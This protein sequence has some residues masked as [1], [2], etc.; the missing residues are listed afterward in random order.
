MI[1]RTLPGTTV[2]VKAGERE[3]KLSA[4]GVVAMPL[5]L[6]WGDTVTVIERGERT[7]LP[8]GYELGDSKLKLPNEVLRSAQRL[9][10]YRLNA[11][12]PKAQATVAAGITAS[13]KHGGARGNDLKLT[14]TSIE[15]RWQI[16]TFLGT[17]EVDAQTIA[18]VADFVNNG[19]ITLAGSGDLAA[20]TVSLSGGSDGEIESGAYTAFMNELEKQQYNII[21][22]TGSDSTVA[23]SLVDFVERQ[24]LNDVNVQLVQSVISADNKAVY[25]NAVG[26]ITAG[27]T[28]SAAEASATLAGI[29]AK[30]G[31]TGSATYF[32]VA[33]WQDVNPR[34]TK[35]QQEVK[36]K[37]GEVLFVYMHGAVKL[38]YDINSLTTFTEEN[39]RD[40]CKGLVVRTLDQMASDIKILLDTKAIGKIRNSVDGRARIKGMLVTM[41]KAQYLDRGYLE[42]FNA[43]D[44]TVE[45][46]N[47]RDAIAVTVGVKVA[48]TV[49]KI[50]VTVTTL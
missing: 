28:L 16:K 39:P 21:A 10:L 15:G 30:Q 7:L 1:T 5:S 44:L 8:L 2:D 23:Q 3:A 29:L 40:F 41:L 33:W 48:D 38:L 26:G 20:V 11:G 46:G 45:E 32:D 4:V 25:K 36:T 37:A 43:D 34:L 49:D 50:Y 6:S 47:E 13:A 18:G 14:V 31:I 17:A 27:Y 9:I 19:F 42:A 24:C 12:S 22:Y 35:T